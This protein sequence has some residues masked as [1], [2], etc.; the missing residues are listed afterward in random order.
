MNGAKK[1]N[2]TNHVEFSKSL[3]LNAF[4]KSFNDRSSAKQVIEKV[5]V[6]PI[7]NS[8]FKYPEYLQVCAK[9]VYDE[10][11]LGPEPTDLPGDHAGGELHVGKTT[12]V[13]WPCCM[14]AL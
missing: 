6:Y 10:K 4:S 5:H 1:N 8:V 14:P 9:N 11:M 2:Q 3:C 7:C 12:A 13:F